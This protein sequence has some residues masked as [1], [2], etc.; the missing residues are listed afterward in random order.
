MPKTLFVFIFS[1]PA[2]HSFHVEIGTSMGWVENKAD[3][4]KKNLEEALTSSIDHASV[5][6]TEVVRDGIRE[7]GAELS[8]VVMS[9]S[10][11]VDAKLDK[12]SAELHEQRSFTKSDIKELVD[13]ATERLGQTLDQRVAVIKVELADLVRQKV[14]YL[15][16]EVD[17]FFIQRQRDLARERNRLITNIAISV[18]AALIMAGVS[19]FYHRTL[20]EG[21][22]M[23]GIFRI[24]LLSL[25]AGY[26][27]YLLASMAR[28]YLSMAEH[29][30]D[31]LFLA[32]RYW[33]VLRPGSIFT[34]FMIF[35]GLLLL[36]LALLFPQT[37]MHAVGLDAVLDWLKVLRAGK[38]GG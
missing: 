6:L 36:T 19:L 9:A 22:D 10:A 21:I 23:F 2:M 3:Y 1:G 33:G 15:K 12:I 37:A 7:A 28:K 34:H 32:A 31:M 20:A 17:G 13:Y 35:L 25:S 38:Q 4:V 14:E 27:V 16:T 29:R 18:A 26:G 8:G 24:S 11:E 30:K 5:H